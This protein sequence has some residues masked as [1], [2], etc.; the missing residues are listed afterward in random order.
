M[1]NLIKLSAEVHELLCQQS[2]DDAENNI[3]VASASSNNKQG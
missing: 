1:Q 3:A 2:F